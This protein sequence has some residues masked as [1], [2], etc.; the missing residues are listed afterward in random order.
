MLPH[1]TV[2]VTT[3]PVAIEQLPSTFFQCGSACG[4]LGI[5]RQRDRCIYQSS[6]RDQPELLKDFA[7]ISLHPFAASVMYIPLQCSIITE[8]YASQ[9]ERGGKHF[10][11]KTLTELYTAL[12]QTLLLRYLSETKQPISKIKTLCDLP[13]C[14]YEEL[15]QLAKLAAEG[16]RASYVFSQI[17][18]TQ[19]G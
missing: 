18:A 13:K 8:L 7:H 4:D 5:H 15:M 1:S 9:W 16:I 2:L 17:S 11:P 3:R 6:C 10:A 12:V 14:V 19:W